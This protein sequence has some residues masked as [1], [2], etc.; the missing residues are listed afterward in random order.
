MFTEWVAKHHGSSDAAVSR[1]RSF[2]VQL[3]TDTVQEAH[4]HRRYEVTGVLPTGSGV[5]RL[6]DTLC[7]S[8]EADR[9]GPDSESQQRG[10]RDAS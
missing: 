5:L 8:G 7:F 4:P 9:G 1:Q 6:I 2:P 10:H 3:W